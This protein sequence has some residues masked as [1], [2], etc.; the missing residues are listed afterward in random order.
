MACHICGILVA[1]YQRASL[2]ETGGQSRY[3]E[4][5]AVEHKSSCS[6]LALPFSIP[7]LPWLRLAD[8]LRPENGESIK[9]IGA[10][11]RGWPSLH[12][13]SNEVNTAFC[14]S[15]S[16]RQFYS[17]APVSSGAHSAGQCWLLQWPFLWNSTVLILLFFRNKLEVISL[18]RSTRLEYIISWTSN[19]Q[20]VPVDITFIV[21]YI[22]FLANKK[23]SR[24]SHDYI[25]GITSSDPATPW[26]SVCFAINSICLS[27]DVLQSMVSRVVPVTSGIS[28]PAERLSL[29]EEGL[30]ALCS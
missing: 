27:Q 26:F 3:G 15:P 13:V 18:S 8:I 12:A 25:R 6:P 30:C 10:N 9:V 17:P 4:G 2:T 20:I 19:L 21:K 1:W 16:N 11:L 29:P 23:L 7:L 14:R 24:A 28:W 5:G 22:T